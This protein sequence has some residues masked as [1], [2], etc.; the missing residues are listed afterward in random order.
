MQLSDKGKM[1]LDLMLVKYAHASEANVSVPEDEMRS[2]LT[3]FVSYFAH[4][5]IS[6]EEQALI[7]RKLIY[8]VGVFKPMDEV[9]VDA[10]AYEKQS[11]DWFSRIKDEHNSWFNA[12]KAKLCQKDWSP[13]VIRELD[14]S[15]DAIMNYLGNPKSQEFNVRGLIM[16][17]IQSGKTANF[18][19]LCNK[20]ADAGYRVII[21]TAGIIEKLRRQT[22]GRLEKEFI[23]LIAGKQVVKLTGTTYDFKK[24]QGENPV[25]V[26]SPE[27]PVLCV[28]KKN[29]TILQYLYK[30]LQK[31]VA[32]SSE[33]GDV[34]LPWPLLF[35]DDEADNASINTK[36]L[37]EE[38]NP[39]KTNE[40]I[41]R[42][43]KS[44][45]RSSY[46]G[47]TATPFANV[48]IDPDTE[49]KVVADDLFP[50]SFVYRLTTPSN[51]FGAEKLFASGSPYLKLIDDIEFWLPA[52]HKKEDF[53]SDKMPLS[54]RTAIGYFLL[55]NGVMDVM[56]ETGDTIGH[57]SM[58]IHI[59]RFIP[60]QNRLA[61]IVE[62]YVKRLTTRIANYG[63]SPDKA[64][65]IEELRFLN[66]IWESFRLAEHCDSMSWHK[67]LSRYLYNAVRMVE[68]IVVNSDRKANALDYENSNKRVIVIGGNALSRG[69]TLYGLVVS[70]FRRNTMMSDTL[71]QMG[72]WC[73]YRDSYQPLVRVWMPE[74]ALDDFGYA[75]DISEDIS[76]MFHQIVEQ[77]G[78]PKDFAFRIRKSPGAMLP[79]A[80]NKMRSAT[81]V[82]FPVILS[83]HA[84]E[85]PRMRNDA[86]IIAENNEAVVDFIR[87]NVS[88]LESIGDWPNMR[89]F[90]GV[91]VSSISRMLSKIKAGMMSYGFMIPQIEDYI[92]KMHTDWDVAVPYDGG[93]NAFDACGRLPFPVKKSGRKLAV[94][95]SGSEIEV[96]GTK[97][98]VTSGGVMGYILTLNERQKAVARFRSIRGN[99]QREPPDS[100]YLQE[101]K[102]LGKRPLL[103]LQYVTMSS[104][105][106]ESVVEPAAK[107]FFAFSFG[108]PG[109]KDDQREEEF[110][111]TR[112]AYEEVS[113]QEYFNS[114][115]EV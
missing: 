92:S 94:T 99:E 56:G 35:I 14:R 109:S 48:F 54:L 77:K 6:A 22:Q 52:S 32:S 93:E 1:V 63:C 18:I 25:H 83:G 105:C 89:F 23:N 70:Y 79:T 72:R 85:T 80:R 36:E 41:R 68:T 46:V 71:L 88:L 76:D 61:E 7:L 75:S 11:P 64:D 111:F 65:S 84:I 5:E 67:F 4:D 66:G 8:S 40:L 15:S 102:H 26:F 100:F 110:Y 21:V 43:L 104:L 45:T 114:E 27:V 34:L 19:A 107:E 49:S 2:E 47:I 44:F 74:H 91:K 115:T 16:G 97:L 106:E 90:R 78:T 13:N 39:T 108:F 82:N 50:R 31:G 28:V 10:T 69:L 81:R 95:N 55:V 87:E 12:Y 29:V 9:I 62:A 59:S 58:M 113:L 42:I 53:P 33:G 24:E 57:R 98:K 17:D 30:W 37:S 96:S 60:I 3:K 112:R 103:V 20:A 101:A 86:S 51:Y 73:G 38:T